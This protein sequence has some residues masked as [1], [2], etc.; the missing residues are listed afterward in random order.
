MT[1]GFT[2]QLGIVDGLLVGA[3]ALSPA[4]LT[5]IAGIGGVSVLHSGAEIVGVGQ[6]IID[7]GTPGCP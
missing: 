5:T 6:A 3:P 7:A 4:A 2:G 1:N